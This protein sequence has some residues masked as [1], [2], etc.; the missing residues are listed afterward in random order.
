MFRRSS[1]FPVRVLLRTEGRPARWSYL[2]EHNTE[3]HAR[4]TFSRACFDPTRPHAPVIPHLP[5]IGKP[6][7]HKSP[8]RDDAPGE[9]VRGFDSMTGSWGY[10]KDPLTRGHKGD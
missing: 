3:K 5:F 1:S 9:I 6:N 4:L 8:K 2:C 7:G 10:S